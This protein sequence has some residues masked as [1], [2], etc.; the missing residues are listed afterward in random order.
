MTL[1]AVIFD[2]D[3]TLAETER[4]RHRVAFNRAFE[5]AGLEDR[6]DESLYGELLDVSG[7]RERIM[8]YFR[9]RRLPLPEDPERMATEIHRSK[10]KEFRELIRGG[11]LE[12]RPGILGLIEELS[13][14]GVALA[15][16]TTGTRSAVLDLLECLKPGLTVRFDGI[17]TADEAPLK[18]PDPQVYEIVLS[19]LGVSANEALAVEDSRN[20][21]IAAVGAGI[22]CLVAVSEYNV[23]DL[24]EEAVLLTD[25]IGEP[26]APVNVLMDPHGVAPTKQS[27]VDARLMRELVSRASSEQGREGASR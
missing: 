22:P 10:V 16:A 6:W 17:F 9:D 21:L 8:R 14:A 20:G 13:D 1:E 27:V 3:G 26:G 15:I 24:F 18:K 7:G 4:H 12:A 25:G 5:K 11:E 23:G 19:E 2:V